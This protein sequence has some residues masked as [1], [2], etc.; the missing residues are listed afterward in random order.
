[1]YIYI[2]VNTLQPLLTGGSIQEIPKAPTFV[3]T[4]AALRPRT[5]SLQ[6]LGMIYMP[7]ELAKLFLTL[8]LSETLNP[9]P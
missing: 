9:K 2:C 5:C 3:E 1:M 4:W 8:P 6:C 7:E